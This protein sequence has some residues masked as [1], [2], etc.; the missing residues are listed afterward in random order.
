MQEPCLTRKAL[1]TKGS[2]ALPRS[3]CAGWEEAVGIHKQKGCHSPQ[4]TSGALSSLGP[5]RAVGS[6]ALE[7]C[8]IPGWLLISRRGVPGPLRVSE[9]LDIQAFAG[10]QPGIC[11]EPTHILT[12]R[13][14]LL[15]MAHNSQTQLRVTVTGSIHSTAQGSVTETKI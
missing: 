13:L 3:R 2:P 10:K 14:T 12:Q 15:E 1:W 7:N 5:W 9:S 4:K 8:K 11:I 6:R